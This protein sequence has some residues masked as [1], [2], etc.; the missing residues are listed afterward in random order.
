[1]EHRRRYRWR[2]HVFLKSVICSTVNWNGLSVH[3]GN[4]LGTKEKL[5]FLANYGTERHEALRLVPVQK[6][7]KFVYDGG[8]MHNSVLQT[9]PNRALHRAFVT[10]KRCSSS[11]PCPCFT[12]IR[13]PTLSS[14]QIP[15]YYTRPTLGT[16]GCSHMLWTAC[17]CIPHTANSGSK[18]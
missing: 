1:M 18:R 11:S 6:K 17:L 16:G 8:R 3:Y 2:F 13:L 5:F 14:P 4:F 12:S 10:L 9:L 15:L 7:K